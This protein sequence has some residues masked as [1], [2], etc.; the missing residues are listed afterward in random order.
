MPGDI[1]IDNDV[2]MGVIGERW[3]G[4]AQGQ[5]NVVLIAVGTGIGAG[6]ILGEKSTAAG[7]GMPAK[8]A[9]STLILL[10]QSRS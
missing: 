6:L 7:G 3:K 4:A 1:W 8:S 2:N 10:P 5:D 9:I